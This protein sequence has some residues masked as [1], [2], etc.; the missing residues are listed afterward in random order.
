MVIVQGQSQNHIHGNNVWTLFQVPI[1]ENVQMWNDFPWNPVSLTSR[2]FWMDTL[3]LPASPVPLSRPYESPHRGLGLELKCGS[4]RWRIGRRGPVSRLT[5]VLWSVWTTVLWAMWTF[6]KFHPERQ[7][8]SK[9][10]S[11]QLCPGIWISFIHITGLFTKTLFTSTDF[12]RRLYCYIDLS[13]LLYVTCIKSTD[14]NN[15]PFYHSR[16]LTY[17]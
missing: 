15:L 6:E 12:T 4:G 5:K 7:N 11:H 3:T 16:M 1:G 14:S 13:C 8:K 2:L 10:K 9:S 17:P